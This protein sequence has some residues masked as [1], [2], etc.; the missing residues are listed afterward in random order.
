MFDPWSPRSASP[1]KTATL[2]FQ[3]N[4][5]S[6]EIYG[7]PLFFYCTWQVSMGKNIKLNWEQGSKPG[8]NRM[9]YSTRGPWVAKSWWPFQMV[10]PPKKHGFCWFMTSM[11]QQVSTKFLGIILVGGWPTPL[12]S[13]GITGFNQFPAPCFAHG[14]IPHGQSQSFHSSASSRPGMRRFRRRRI[15]WFPTMGYR[16]PPLIVGNPIYKWMSCWGT[17]MDWKPPYV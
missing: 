5:A 10:N 16:V 3:K 11:I 17:L 4:V 14:I 2:W 1:L 9:V 15:A 8:W 7:N 13:H 6:W 12:K